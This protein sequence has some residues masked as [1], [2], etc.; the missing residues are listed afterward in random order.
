M[1]VAEI[2]KL[3]ESVGSPTSTLPPRKREAAK[4]TARQ[5]A[6]AAQEESATS[7]E[8]KSLEG[9]QWEF[10]GKLYE[11]AAGPKTADDLGEVKVD[12]ARLRKNAVVL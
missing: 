3:V 6:T 4:S 5:A 12:P 8:R 1:Q 2:D 11:Y 10:R 7:S 9:Q